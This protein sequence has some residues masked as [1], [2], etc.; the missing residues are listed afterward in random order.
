MG[1]VVSASREPSLTASTR[2]LVLHVGI[3]KTASTYI[4]HRFKRN[5]AFLRQRGFLYPKRR[6]DHLRLVKAL[7]RDNPRPWRKLLQR[8]A[9]LGATPLVSAELLSVLL[10][11]PAGDQPNS[12]LLARLCGWLEAA[13]VQLQLVAFVRDQ[14]AYLNS[15]YTQL[16][17]RFYF[18]LPF[19]RYVAQT[20]REGG[21]SECDYERLFAEALADPR[22]HTSFLPFRS[23][24]ADPCERLL[25]ALGVADCGALKPLVQQANAQPGW[26]AVWIAQRLAR[27]LRRRH[28][29]AWR[30]R[31]CKAQIREGLERLAK[32]QGWPAQ[33]FQGVNAELL[34]RI[35]ARYGASNE[36]FA[37]R[38]WGC[39]W[40]SLFPLVAPQPSPQQ[41]RDRA[42]RRSLVV[43]ADRLLTEALRSSASATRRRAQPALLIRLKGMR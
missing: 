40:R 42:E 26:Q 32:S 20:L 7:V 29:Q 39:S 19:A 11:R 36:R 17:K 43:L 16:I 33:P 24:E 15:R 27:Q 35:E 37:Q 6:C 2:R 22:V 4:Q 41:P 34:A 5:Q 18:G 23:G 3:H 9:R 8:A 31:R 12:T 1:S 38:V 14:P 25:A 28:P 21:D 10:H 30:N 13:G